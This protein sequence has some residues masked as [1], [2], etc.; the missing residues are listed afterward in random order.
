MSVDKDKLNEHTEIFDNFM[1]AALDKLSSE[2]GVNIVKVMTAY[3]FIKNAL[4]T[5]NVPD[6]P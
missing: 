5:L 4:P 1:N 2:D 3:N 6:K